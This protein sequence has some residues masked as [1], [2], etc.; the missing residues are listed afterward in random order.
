MNEVAEA[1]EPNDRA[2]VES[3]S[4]QQIIRNTNICPL[5]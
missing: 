4:A 2:D 3:T 5:Q 1:N